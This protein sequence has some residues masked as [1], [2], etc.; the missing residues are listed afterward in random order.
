MYRIFGL[1]PSWG[2]LQLGSQG[3]LM[4]EGTT[5]PSVE[6]AREFMRLHVV[7]PPHGD[8]DCYDCFVGAVDANGLIITTFALFTTP[9]GHTDYVTDSH[10]NVIA[11][12]EDDND[13]SNL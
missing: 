6:D 3:W 5:F 9:A 7:T 8:T 11:K 12:F 2:L 1:W 4:L 10:G 13:G